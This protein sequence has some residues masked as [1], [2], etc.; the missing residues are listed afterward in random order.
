VTGQV[1]AVDA[2]ITALLALIDAA[3][4]VP[5]Y[6][7]IEPTSAADTDLVI[8][9][10]DGSPDAATG[11]PAATVTQE[12]GSFEQGTREET[13]TV[14]GCVI[15]QSGGDDYPTLRASSLATLSAVEAAL[16]ADD[17]LGG[18]VAAGSI[19]S[20]VTFQARNANG[21]IVRRVWTYTYTTYQG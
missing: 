1:T 4:D 16:R 9:G 8:V 21:A 15:S 19:T 3:V 5:V 7:G 14:I 13:G 18:L 12:W 2:V 10:N 20:V 11:E 17:N 6:D